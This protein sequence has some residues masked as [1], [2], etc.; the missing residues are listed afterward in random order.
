MRCPI[1]ADTALE[2]RTV[3]PGVAVRA[4]PHCGGYWMAAVSYWRWRESLSESLPNFDMQDG[5][6]DEANDSAEAKL[7]PVD[8]GFLIR[9]QVGYGLDFYLDRCGRCGGMWLDQGE[10]E[11]LQRR[12]MHDD[13]HLIFTS[14]WQAEVRRQRKA[15]ADEQRLIERLGE[16]DYQRSKEIRA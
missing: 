7:C 1:H 9:H 11:A 16:A 4:C 5:G 14:S 8:G 12:Q 10:W 2:T 13:L 6:E 3:E 15:R